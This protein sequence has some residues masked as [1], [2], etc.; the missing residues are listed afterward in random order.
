MNAILYIPTFNAGKNW[1]AVIAAINEQ[2]TLPH[3]KVIID[4]GSTDQTLSLPALSDYKIIRIPKHTFDHGGTRQYA[5]NQFPD[6][7]LYIFLTQ[8]A[9]LADQYAL[10][11]LIQVFENDPTIGCAYGRQLP[12][13]GA[14]VLEAH[15]RLFSYPPH[16]QL[17]NMNNA[18][19]YG[20]QA[21][22]CSNSFA[23][24]RR[25]AFEEAGGFPNGTILGEDV[26]AAGQ[27]L[28][29]GWQL[30]Y[31]AEA[32]VYHS[33]NYTIA[34]EFKRYFDIGVFHTS[35]SWIFTHFGR[36]S[37]NGLRYVK[38]V[39][40]YVLKRAPWL[41]PK[42]FFSIIAKWLGYA[43]GLRYRHLPL[44]WCRSFSMHSGFW[45]RES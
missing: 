33:H 25:V 39:C 35:H 43:L 4:S 38:S 6:A 5:I 16:A 44:R 41:L 37:G 2:Y 24:Y 42:T 3:Q 1:P 14:R 45:K 13:R 11:H 28:L 26:I 7:D 12:H 32:Q 15:A 34:E 20:I 9:I 40:A 36:A 17:R 27:I 29:H 31:V 8:D 10:H 30:A 23:A 22:S 18:Y 19:R 21:A